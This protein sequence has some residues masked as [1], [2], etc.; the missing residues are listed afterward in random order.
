MANKILGKQARYEDQQQQKQENEEGGYGKARVT[1]YM[2]IQGEEP[3]P[4]F[5]ETDVRDLF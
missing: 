4:K 5:D 3:W 2:R 1:L